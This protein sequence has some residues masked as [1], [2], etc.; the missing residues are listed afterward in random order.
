MRYYILLFL[1]VI[2]NDLVSA[3]IGVRDY[4]RYEG[5]NLAIINSPLEPYFDLFPDLRPYGFCF[6]IT[7]CYSAI[8]EI[9]DSKLYLIELKIFKYPE[10]W[11]TKDVLS[12]VFDGK[13]EVLM[14]WYTSTIV[15]DLNNSKI[16]GEYIKRRKYSHLKITIKNGFVVQKRKSS[17]R[18]VNRLKNKLFRQFKKTDEFRGI[19]E[20]YRKIDITKISSLK[21][22]VIGDKVLDYM[23]KIDSSKTFHKCN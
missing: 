16:K 15:I 20:K 4:L 2:S 11:E 19:R 3:E 5:R 13:A 23:A 17:Y 1:L 8:Y 10:S 22:I 9:R 14:E 6:Q 12:K 18:G 21:K 7:K